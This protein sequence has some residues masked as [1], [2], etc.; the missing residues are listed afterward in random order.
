MIE[1]SK[2]L[3][4]FRDKVSAV[5]KDADNPFFKSKYADLPSILEVI[6]D[7]L[8]ESGLCLYH[9]MKST[10]SGYVVISTITE[11]LSWES[12]TS[13][14]PV[15]GNKPQE[16]GSSI[17]YARRYNIQAMLDIPTEDD[18][19]NKANTATRTKATK[20]DDVK[21]YNDVTKNLDKWKDMVK[22]GKTTPDEIIAKIESEWYKINSANKTLVYSLM[23]IDMT[24]PPY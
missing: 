23:W 12:I 24:N 6:K 3:G 5:K 11:A 13:E 20:Q 1:I 21:W 4:V 17:S 18:D 19:W 14:F 16:I 7:P 10:E 15:F 2:A 9:T 8:K 22:S